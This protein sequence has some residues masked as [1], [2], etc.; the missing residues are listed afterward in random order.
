MVVAVSLDI[1]NAFNTIPHSTIKEALRYHRVPNYLQALLS[2]YLDNRTVCFQD[3]SGQVR[4]HEVGV[5]VPQGSVLGPLLWNIGY[6]WVLRGVFPEGMEVIC[7]ADDTLAVFWGKTYEEAALRA[8]RGASALVEKIRQLGLKV[9]LEK[10]GALFFPGPRFGQRAPPNAHIT[11]GGVRVE[12]KDQM[13]YL[14]LILDG[15]W[16]FKAHFSAL[17]PRLQKAAGGLSWLLPND[18]GPGARCRQL[19]AGILKSMALYGAPIWEDAVRR[20]ETL[21]LLRRPQR[22]I[23]QRVARAYRTTA[24][25]SVCAL[26]A[27]LPWELEARIQAAVYEWMAAEKERGERPAPSECAVKRLDARTAAVQEWQGN[28]AVEPHG[29]RVADAVG[30]VLEEWLERPHGV[31]TYRLVQVMTG[32]GCF[33]SYLHRIGRE[34]TPSCHHCGATEDTAQ[35]TLEECTSF[36]DERR[37]LRAVVGEDLSLPSVVRAMLGGERAWRAMASFCEN[38][39]LQKE[40]AERERERDPLAPPHRRRRG[41]R[42]RRRSDGENGPLAP[43]PPSV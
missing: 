19:Y 7:F 29:R 22:A 8:S 34:E 42:R 30:P 18:K 26:G 3:G 11:I 21:A 31:L 2:D 10:T 23:A 4:R 12:V 38:V 5:G 43:P 24:H 32:H 25:S 20:K 39:V 17:A 6:D 28:L 35:H 16:N 9:A 41:R 40:A 15:R 37:G 14:G 36:E 13:K 1:A 33:G 27:T